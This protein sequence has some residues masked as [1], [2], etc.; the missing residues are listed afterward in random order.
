MA[1]GRRKVAEEASVLDV[2]DGSPIPEVGM[3]EV[4][5]E[6][7]H[8]WDDEVVLAQEEMVGSMA[9]GILERVQH[10]PTVW[11]KMTENQQRDMVS[12]ITAMCE[13]MAR[14]VAHT[15]ASKGRKIIFGAL[16]QVVAGDELMLKISCRKSPVACAVLGM[17]AN[18]EGEN[19]AFLLLNTP[20]G[21]LELGSPIKVGLVQGE[22]PL[23]DGCPDGPT[24]L[25][26]QFGE[27]SPPDFID[28]EATVG[29]EECPL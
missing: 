29:P 3:G 18:A 14:Q 19:V 8:V 15:I 25:P 26:P 13:S 10:M 5:E 27:E 6:Q 12:G 9:K 23:E 16:K 11:Q 2:V 4:V 22:L 28:T 1:R 7:I 24:S 20:E 17:A 21:L